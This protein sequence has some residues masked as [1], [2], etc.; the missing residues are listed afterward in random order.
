MPIFLICFQFSA[1]SS[2]S[3]ANFP[4]SVRVDGRTHVCFNRTPGEFGWCKTEVS[5]RNENTDDDDA[6]GTEAAKEW[7]GWGFCKK[8]C[9]PGNRAVRRIISHEDMP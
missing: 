8:Y 2:A 5:D 3:S 1:S 4:V 7:L 6:D 9:S